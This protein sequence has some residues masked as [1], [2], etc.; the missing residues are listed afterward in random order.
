M[1]VIHNAPVFDGDEGMEL[2][3]FAE[4]IATAQLVKVI[5]PIR[6]RLVVVDEADIERIPREALDR[7]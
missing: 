3:R 5:E 7:F 6:R 1:A 2:V 4:P